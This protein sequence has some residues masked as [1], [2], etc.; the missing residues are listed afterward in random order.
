MKKIAALLLC[1]VFAGG[2]GAYL[3]LTWP[4]PAGGQSARYLPPDA[5]AAVRLTPLN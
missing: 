4:P 5:L 3:Y 2:V 1:L